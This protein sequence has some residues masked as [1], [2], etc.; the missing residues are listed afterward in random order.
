MKTTV[1]EVLDTLIRPVGRL[2][3]TVD[4]LLTGT[5]EMEV[6][7]IATAFVAT[8]HVIEQAAASGANLVI[9]HEGTY[10]SHHRH[11][12]QLLDGNSVYREKRQLIDASGIAVLRFHD[13]P[14][15]YQ[16]DG[17]TLGLIQ[18]LGWEPYV[19]KH[20]PEAAILILPARK[21]RE[22][23]EYVKN[24]L[25]APFVRIAGELSMSCT[26]IGVAVG[27]RG[28]SAVTL[29]LF[30]DEQL[31]LIIAGEGPEWETPEYIRDAVHQG[32][33]KALIFT[34]HA[35]SEAPGMRRI[36]AQLQGAF[37]HLHVRFIADKPIF[38]AV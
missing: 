23:A 32:K 28:G 3:A 38:Q 9:T 22:I 6:T 27:Y 20:R 34:G 29:P 33:K 5:P 17:I 7:G 30:E 14:H 12:E 11:S 2:E 36:A 24:A 31:D 15:R 21:V 26:R 16:P 37:P 8:Q 25:S 18:E 19:D 1:Q 35:E 13:Y 4:T 10:Y